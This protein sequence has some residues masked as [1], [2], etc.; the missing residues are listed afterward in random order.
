MAL[1]TTNAG[2]LNVTKR[3]FKRRSDENLQE[4]L[5]GKDKKNTQKA[6]QGALAQFSQYLRSKGHPKIEDL[7]IECLPEILYSFYPAVKPLKSD[8]YSVQ[9]LKCLRAGLNRYFRKEKGFDISKD[10]PFVRANEMFQAV[11][12]ESK[13]NGKGVRKSY[14]PISPID[15]ERLSEH[16]LHDHMNEPDPKKL[17]QQMIFNI[18]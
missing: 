15:L 10:P 13:K 18:I 12:V 8:I 9:T 1:E 17:Q 16:F 5:E 2:D 14:P 6:T 11:L 4:L 3:D 7:T